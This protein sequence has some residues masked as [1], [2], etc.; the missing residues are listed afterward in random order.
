MR[1]RELTEGK[2]LPSIIVDVQPAYDH[3][4]NFFMDDLVE[5]IARQRGPILMFVNA[6][7]TGMTDDNVEHEIFPWWEENF[8]RAGYDFYEH[9][10]DKMEFIDKGYG[11]LR[12][13]M[14]IGVPDKYIIRTIR[15]MY[16][17]KVSDSRELFGGDQSQDYVENMASLGIPE[18]V[19]QDPIS[20][21]WVS[22]AKL[23]QY[24]GGYIMGGSREECLREVEL[25]MNAFNLPARRVERFIYG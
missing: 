25:M 12:G 5:F 20:V 14:D 23:K 19:L 16:R 15:E 13:W 21:V 2:N 10:L 17:Q 4:I 18:R 22:I 3:A 1:F 9:G 6:D 24:S 11:Y 7:E 8:E